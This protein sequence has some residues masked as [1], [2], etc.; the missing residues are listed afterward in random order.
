M[1]SLLATKKKWFQVIQFPASPTTGM[2]GTE[3][4]VQERRVV[5]PLC[6]PD[7]VFPGLRFNALRL[8]AAFFLLS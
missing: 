2:H 3:L 8:A 1:L 5:P 7:A 6:S 4:R